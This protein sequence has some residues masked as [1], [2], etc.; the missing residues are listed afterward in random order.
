M[1]NEYFAFIASAYGIST[2]ALAGLGL[3]VFLDARAQRRDL[4]DLDARGVRRRSSQ[5]PGSASPDTPSQS[6]AAGALR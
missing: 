6:D 4:K 3:W 5:T 2:V 1:Q